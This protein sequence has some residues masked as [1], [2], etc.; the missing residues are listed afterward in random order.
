MPKEP[1][2]TLKW[3]YHRRCRLANTVYE[4]FPEWGNVVEAEKLMLGLLNTRS[5]HGEAAKLLPELFEEIRAHNEAVNAKHSKWRQDR[6]DLVS[7]YRQMAVLGTDK[8]C[9]D[10]AAILAK[11]PIPFE[12]GNGRRC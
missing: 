4:K 1:K 3:S 10:L 9:D 7:K 12:H 2:S 6:S 11:N 8:Q 5:F